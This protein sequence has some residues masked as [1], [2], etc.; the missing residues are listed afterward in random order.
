MLT[1]SLKSNKIGGVGMYSPPPLFGEWMN[2]SFYIFATIYLILIQALSLTV[3][4][5]GEVQIAAWKL[6]MPSF[7]LVGVV[8]MYGISFYL[9]RKYGQ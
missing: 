4:W 3:Y 2:S 7:C 6:Y 9:E 5:V 8:I 1:Q